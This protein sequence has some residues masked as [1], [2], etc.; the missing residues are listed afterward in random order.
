MPDQNVIFGANADA[1]IEIYFLVHFQKIIQRDKDKTLEFSIV[2]GTNK[3]QISD[4]SA[5]CSIK[6]VVINYL[7]QRY[8][9][10]AGYLTFE[11]T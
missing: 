10:E 4:I 7:Q 8:V 6:Y 1:D 3:I 11:Q 9:M 2:T 5:G